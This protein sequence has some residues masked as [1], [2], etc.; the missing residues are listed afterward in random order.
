[1]IGNMLIKFKYFF[2]NIF[3]EFSNYILVINVNWDEEWNN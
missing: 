1:M 3:E 2:V